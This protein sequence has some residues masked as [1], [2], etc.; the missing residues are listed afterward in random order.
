[1]ST[2]LHEVHEQ[3]SVLFSIRKPTSKRRG[4]GGTGNLIRAPYD[5]KGVRS[6]STAL[7]HPVS[8]DHIN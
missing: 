6:I 5:K 4:E 1:M 3:T 2:G 7:L 8:F